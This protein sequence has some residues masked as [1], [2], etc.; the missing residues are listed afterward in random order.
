M[1]KFTEKSFSVP[2]ASGGVSDDE[3]ARRWEAT[4]GKKA[5]PEGGAAEPEADA[6][7]KKKRK[8]QKK[9]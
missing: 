1:T 7:K 5:D 3:L 4:F 9:E 6:A 2:C 8:A